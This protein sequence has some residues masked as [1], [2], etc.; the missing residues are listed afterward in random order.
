MTTILWIENRLFVDSAIIKGEERFQSLTKVVK[1]PTPLKMTSA[2]SKPFNDTIYG[3]TCTGNL[4]TAGAFMFMLGLKGEFDVVDKLYDQIAHLSVVGEGFTF[5]IL[6]IGKKQNYLFELAIGLWSAR[7]SERDMMTTM[8]SGGGL[9]MEE[10][11][12]GND[13]IRSFMHAF[14]MQPTTTGGMIDVWQLDTNSEDPFRRMGLYNQ[15]TREEV[16]EMLRDMKAPVPL[17]LVHPP[18]LIYPFPPKTDAL[19]K[20]PTKPTRLSRR[21]I[22]TRTGAKTK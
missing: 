18:V 5:S 12:K 6:A 10:M 19:K 17:D 8:G 21:V 15:R 13:P 4:Q 1:L 7:V 11:K 2:L 9:V 22:P 3:W 16:V 14:Y 20:A